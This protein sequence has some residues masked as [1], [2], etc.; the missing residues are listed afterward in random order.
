MNIALRI[1]AGLINLM[2]LWNA[3]QFLF[4]PA[5]AT[6]GLE[7][8]LLTGAGASTQLGDIGGF[9]LAGAVILGLG[10]RHGQSH[11]FYPAIILFCSAAAMRTLVAVAGHADFLPQF[12]IPEIVMAAILFAAA[13][14]RADE[15]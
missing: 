4:R 11:W 6:A 7:M 9:F 1:L 14:A 2:M 15:A 13:R 8:D 12:I 5:A 3:L 10:Q